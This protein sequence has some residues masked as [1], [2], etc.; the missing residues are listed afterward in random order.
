MLADFQ[1]IES[2]L[3]KRYLAIDIESGEVLYERFE[4]NKEKCLGSGYDY[5][6]NMVLTVQE[7]PNGWKCKTVTDKDEVVCVEWVPPNDKRRRGGKKSYIKLNPAN[8]TILP[9]LLISSV[10]KLSPYIMTNGVLKDAKR[11]RNLT[12]DAVFSIWGFGRDKN[13]K[14]W[15]E[16]V[17]KQVLV[18]AGKEIKLNRDFLARG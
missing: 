2:K 8:I 5:I 15:K 14:I 6:G 13:A 18:V 12:K 3:G 17:D 9:D 1:I 7:L 11:R 4:S 16:L 10:V